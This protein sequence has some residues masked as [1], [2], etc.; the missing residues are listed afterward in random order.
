[1]MSRGNRRQARRKQDS[2]K[3]AMAR[4]LRQE[5]TLSV[6]QIA[7]PSPGH[8]S[9]RQCPPAGRFGGAGGT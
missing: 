2:A 5:T 9:K 7:S 3:L 8:N 6:K 4:R 1:M